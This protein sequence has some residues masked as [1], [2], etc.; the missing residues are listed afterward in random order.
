[1]N[2]LNPRVRYHRRGPEDNRCTRVSILLSSLDIVN[3]PTTRC[4]TMFRFP[5]NEQNEQILEKFL[6]WIGQTLGL[7]LTFIALQVKLGVHSSQG[8][9]KPSSVPPFRFSRGSVGSCLVSPP[10]NVHR[11]HSA[12]FKRTYAIL[13][14]TFTSEK[15]GLRS[16]VSLTTRTPYDGCLGMYDFSCSLPHDQI[17]P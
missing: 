16:I 13:P 1:M 14:I 3:P 15:F 9:R 11:D 2:N 5:K 4:V 7:G 6:L 17:I 12:G 10:P 8:F